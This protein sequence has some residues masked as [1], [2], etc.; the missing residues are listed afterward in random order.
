MPLIERLVLRGAYVLRRVPAVAADA[1]ADTP[2]F[3]RTLD[4]YYDEF[5]ETVK[6]NTFA[7]CKDEFF[8]T[9]TLCWDLEF[10]SHSI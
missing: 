6:N 9:K 8:S 1:L 10:F 2:H 7:K 4:A 3:R 5:V